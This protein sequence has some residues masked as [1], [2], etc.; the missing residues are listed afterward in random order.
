M[1]ADEE[2]STIQKKRTFWYHPHFRSLVVVYMMIFFNGCCFTAVAPSVP[3]YLQ[4]LNAPSN[5]LGFVVSLYS[6]GQIF[7]SPMSGWL[8][9][10]RHVCSRTILTIS[11]TLGI[12][13]S[14]LYA[15][16]PQYNWLIISRFFT[17]I[18]AGFEFTTELTFIA[19]VTTISERTTFLA[20]V[21]A[22]NVLG[23]ILG[24]ALDVIFVNMNVNWLGG[25][26]VIDKYTGPGWLLTSMFVVD[27]ILVRTVFESK[28]DVDSTID[29]KRVGLL[30][31]DDHQTDDVVKDATGRGIDVPKADMEEPHPSL[32][33]VGS[34]IFVQFSL[35]CGF[36]LLETITSPLVQDQFE[37]TVKHSDIL[38]TCGGL[39]SLLLY[40]T[41]V[42]LSKRIEDR[43][44]VLTA[45]VLCTIGFFL[46]VDWSQ[47]TWV[48]QWLVRLQP[49][50]LLRFL[51]GFALVYAG[52]MTGRSL[53]FALYSK[54]IPQE[55][56]GMYLGWMV[57]GGSAARAL[58]PFFAVALYYRNQE[59]GVILFS[60]FGSL[61][62]FHL[63]SVLL[64]V[65][66]WSKLL[67]PEQTLIE[68]TD[69]STTSQDKELV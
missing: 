29:S 59:A 34:L 17:G 16:I 12:F 65:A 10:E 3:F 57:S 1:K 2:P 63:C 55:H 37:W 23:F 9:S 60:L 44:L 32:F 54:L 50:Y 18:S 13:S 24:P 35:M 21:T 26:I 8:S 22:C 68:Q 53:V 69:C 52:F 7:G 30:K 4:Q 66:L 27:L 31:V 6:V 19:H 58:G 48:P 67:S 42:T 36:S 11:S 56:Q 15:L 62:L 39:G 5:I 43:T 40:V 51:V 45:L 20:S 38:F 33:V 41:F 25:I 64:V 61:G 28:A 46:A 47:L 49:P 14:L